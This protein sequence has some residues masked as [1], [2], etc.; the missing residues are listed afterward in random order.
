MVTR[1]NG[2]FTLI[3]FMVVI[4]IMGILMSIA[5]PNVREWLVVQRI[6]DTTAS[7][8]SSAVRARN[9]AINRGRAVVITPVGGDWKNGWD[10]P[11]P[12]PTRNPAPPAAP[13]VFI[14]R[15]SAVQDVIIEGPV[16]LSF[17]VVGRITAAT[18]F[19]V[20]AEGTTVARCIRVDTAGRPKTV[21][22]ESGDTC[23]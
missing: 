8:H 6:K 21:V 15:N 9:E 1:S 5:L 19:K 4:A 23:P 10:I 18:G 3:E 16:S 17:S 12:D 20:R 22:I 11:D 13:V 14:E 7:L 2:G